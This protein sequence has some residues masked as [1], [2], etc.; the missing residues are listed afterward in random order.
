MSFLEK[1]NRTFWMQPHFEIGPR[2]KMS[3]PLF[4]EEGMKL[5][6]SSVHLLVV[7][8]VIRGDVGRSVCINVCNDNNMR[9]TAVRI[10]WT[11]DSQPERTRLGHDSL[12]VAIA[13]CIRCGC[14]GDLSRMHL[15]VLSD[16]GWSGNALAVHLASWWVLTYGCVRF[17]AG[18]CRCDRLIKWRFEC[19]GHTW[20]RMRHMESY[21][22]GL[23][24][25]DRWDQMLDTRSGPD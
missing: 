16:G 17:V 20:D 14:C 3:T 19:C 11:Y 15:D 5:G 22:W 6:N 23:G 13:H 10:P 25:G 18:C 24:E 21:E 12:S 2:D 7:G 8:G 9:S 4:V 1:L